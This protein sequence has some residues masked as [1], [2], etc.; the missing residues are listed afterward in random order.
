[1]CLPP[2]EREALIRSYIDSIYL[3]EPHWNANKL[4]WGPI[5]KGAVDQGFFKTLKSSD[6]SG[7]VSIHIEYLGRRV[8]EVVDAM[9]ENFATVKQLLG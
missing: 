2:I 8:P 4:D 9:H 7:P 3:K 5:G 6:F 1:M